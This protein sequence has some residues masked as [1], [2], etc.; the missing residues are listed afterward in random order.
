MFVRVSVMRESVCLCVC[1]RETERV[2]VCVRA[3]DRKRERGELERGTVI[4]ID[5]QD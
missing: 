2:N 5:L 1:E 4:C 3:C